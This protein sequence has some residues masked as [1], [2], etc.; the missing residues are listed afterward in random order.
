LAR[1]GQ[2]LRVQRRRW[3]TVDTSRQHCTSRATPASTPRAP[4]HPSP[5]SLPSRVVVP[6]LLLHSPRART[7]D[8][9]QQARPR[10]TP[11]EPLQDGT[12]GTVA[13]RLPGERLVHAASTALHI[14]GELFGSP[15]PNEDGALQPTDVEAS[16]CRIEQRPMGGSSD[17][18]GC[19]ARSVAVINRHDALGWLQRQIH[20][21][22]VES[23]CR[24]SME[25]SPSVAR[26]RA[27]PRAPPHKRAETSRHCAARDSEIGRLSATTRSVCSIADARRLPLSR[28]GVATTRGRAASHRIRID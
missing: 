16:G 18:G 3:S 6:P 28:L 11:M 22:R 7:G 1:Y 4:V 2:C 13:D 14:Q 17:E 24:V 15:T 21:W 23:P 27:P 25:M 9:V 8:S 5:T 26:H 10:L 12:R 19:A 20:L